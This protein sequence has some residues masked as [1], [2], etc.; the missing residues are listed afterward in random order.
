MTETPS[1]ATNPTRALDAQEKGPTVARQE[2]PTLV[3]R[4]RKV[5]RSWRAAPLP[6]LPP[7]QIQ[8][9][10]TVVRV[11]V[12]EER[13]VKGEAAKRAPKATLDGP[14]R[15]QDDRGC[16]RWPFV[17]RSMVLGGSLWA[18]SPGYFLTSV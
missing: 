9:S 18:S 7:R 14:R 15:R 5:T 2:G 13:A 16:R 12:G 11:S 8:P 4:F 10:P 3:T 1:K 17:P 6:H